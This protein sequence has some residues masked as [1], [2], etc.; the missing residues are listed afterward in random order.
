M[1]DV[2]SDSKLARYRTISPLGTG[3]MASVVL[4]E[5]TLLGRRVALKRMHAS[6]A[7]AR[8]GVLF[9]DGDGHCPRQAF[10]QWIWIRHACV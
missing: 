3:G 10:F 2:L 7:D 9:A 4:G 5:D 6:A 8:R 1:R